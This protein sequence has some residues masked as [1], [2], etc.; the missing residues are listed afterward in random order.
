MN[1]ENSKL[2]KTEEGSINEELEEYV[3]TLSSKKPFNLES[4][5]IKKNQGLLSRLVEIDLKS[6]SYKRF[7][8]GQSGTEEQFTEV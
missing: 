7:I 1:S 3:D 4:E 8:V 5:Q 2:I 6:Q